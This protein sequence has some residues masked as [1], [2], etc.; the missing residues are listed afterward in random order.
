MKNTI[1]TALVATA[2]LVLAACSTSTS[3]PAPEQHAQVAGRGHDQGSE[4]CAGGGDCAEQQMAPGQQVTDPVL[5]DYLNIHR[6][7]A[8]DSVAGVIEAARRLAQATGAHQ[9]HQGHGEVATAVATAARALDGSPDLAAAR[10]RFKALSEQM[11]R[12]RAQHPAVAGQTIVVHCSMAPGSWVQL[13]GPVQNPYYGLSML[14]C[15]DVTRRQGQ[16]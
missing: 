7:L 16:V 3:E 1:G 9:A 2:V 14:A 8:A 6:A 15:G 13:A 4:H 11:I 12:Y 5:A 10:E